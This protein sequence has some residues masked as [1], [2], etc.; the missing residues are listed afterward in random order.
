MAD[1]TEDEITTAMRGLT[2]LTAAMLA[3]MAA[4]PDRALILVGQYHPATRAAADRRGLIYPVPAGEHRLTLLGEAV[5][6]RMSIQ[7]GQNKAVADPIT[8]QAV[9]AAAT[10]I[11]D[12]LSP[13]AHDCA[14]IYTGQIG[15][16]SPT[17]EDLARAVL[18][19]ALPIIHAN[20]STAAHVHTGECDHRVVPMDVEGA[21]ECYHCGPHYGTSRYCHETCP[22]P[23]DRPPADID[24]LIAEHLVAWPGWA[25][26]RDLLASG[27]A[28]SGEDRNTTLRGEPGE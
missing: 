14:G 21:T 26:Q 20:A 4:Q 13:H 24:T 22:A 18:A 17:N 2:P 16:L 12:L 23:D 27:T 15:S 11:H 3:D 9:A 1:P 7:T 6:S 5:M 8:D 19:A 25:V 10:A 28:P